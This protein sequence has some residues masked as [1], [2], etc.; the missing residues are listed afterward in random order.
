M[1]PIIAAL[2]LAVTALPALAQEWQVRGICDMRRNPGPGRGGECVQL[3]TEVLMLLPDKAGP[4][5][6]AVIAEFADN[7]EKASVTWEA[8]CPD[9]KHCPEAAYTIRY[10]SV[11]KKILKLAKDQ[12]YTAFVCREN[13][14]DTPPDEAACR[15]KLLKVVRELVNR[16]RREGALLALIKCGGQESEAIRPDGAGARGYELMYAFVQLPD[17]LPI[18]GGDPKSAARQALNQLVEPEKGQARAAV[19]PASMPAQAGQAAKAM[20][21][22]APASGAAAGAA[23][24]AAGSAG[25][26]MVGTVTAGPGDIVLQVAALP[27][28]VQAET[29]SDRLSK[30]GIESG[31]ERAEVNGR[32]VYRVL[33]KG[34]GSPD[35]FRQKLAE[36]GYPGAIQRR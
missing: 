20:P 12:I 28:L 16:A 33:A 14:S 23:T 10:T 25:F 22:S 32:E 24:G 21:A 34:R 17:L 8:P 30:A 11:S 6:Y 31:F 13:F 18:A 15:L 4:E 27:N 19:Q 26:V 36:M 1:K 7:F 2:L 29:L 5:N 35:V 3:A 9:P